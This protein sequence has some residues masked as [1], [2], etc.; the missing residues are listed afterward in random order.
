MMAD[1]IPHDGKIQR[2]LVGLTMTA[3]EKFV[4]PDWVTT[5]LMTG[6]LMLSAKEG[7]VNKRASCLSGSAGVILGDAILCEPEELE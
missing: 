5:E 3:I 1:F 2:C 4:G 6:D 7:P